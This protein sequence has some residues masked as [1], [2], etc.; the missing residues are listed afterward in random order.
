MVV[1]TKSTKWN[2]FFESENWGFELCEEDCE[3]IDFYHSV[4]IFILY[5]IKIPTE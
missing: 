2:L 1:P 5:T 3:G 4:G